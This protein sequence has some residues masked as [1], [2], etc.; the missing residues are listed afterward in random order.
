MVRAID[1]DL[2]DLW[3]ATVARAARLLGDAEGDDVAGVIC[4]VKAFGAHDA[5]VVERAVSISNENAVRLDL[6]RQVWK[7]CQGQTYLQRKQH[8]PFLK[9]CV[10]E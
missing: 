6:V 3:I 10:H 8:S 7:A 9:M 1:G 4:R 5:R 2:P